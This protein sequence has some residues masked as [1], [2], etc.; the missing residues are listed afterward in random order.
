DIPGDQLNTVGRT[1]KRPL[2]APLLLKITSLLVRKAR[3]NLVEPVVDR[4][5]VDVELWLALLVEKRRHRAV[6]NGTLHGVGMN[7]RPELAGR[8]LVLDKR[9]TRKGYIGSIGQRLAHALMP[10]TA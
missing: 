3:R 2:L 7:D 4:L 6:F 8:L 9:R 10:L 5:F 1:I